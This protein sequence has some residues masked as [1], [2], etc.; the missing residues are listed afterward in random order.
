MSKCVRCMRSSAWTCLMG[1]LA[2]WI[3]VVATFAYSS[4]MELASEEGWTARPPPPYIFRPRIYQPRGHDSFRFYDIPRRDYL[5]RR[6][7]HEEPG[8]EL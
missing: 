6:R 5:P 4:W 8:V 2:F 3:G 7:A 1:V